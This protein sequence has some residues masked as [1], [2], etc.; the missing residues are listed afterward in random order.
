MRQRRDDI[1][2]LVDRFIARFNERLGTS[3]QAV[4]PKAMRVLTD[5]AWPGNVRELE[6]AIERAMVLC[7]NTVL[8]WPTSTRAFKDR[9]PRWRRAR[10]GQPLDQEDH[11]DHRGDPHP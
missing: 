10:E 5:Y 4:D 6:H 3:I 1:P 7:G 11:A 2:L 9:R 8:T